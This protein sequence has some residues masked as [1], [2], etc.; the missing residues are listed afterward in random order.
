MKKENIPAALIIS[1]LL[2]VAISGAL[3]GSEFFQTEAKAYVESVHSFDN[4]VTLFEVPNDV[5]GEFGVGV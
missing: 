3:S 4:P 5:K 1:I 2:L